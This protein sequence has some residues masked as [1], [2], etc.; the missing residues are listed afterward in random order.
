MPASPSRPAIPRVLLALLVLRARPSTPLH[1]AV[2]GPGRARGGSSFC[3][4][5]LISN[6]RRRRGARL[7][8]AAAADGAADEAANEA[9]D[10]EGGGLVIRDSGLV[11]GDSGVRTSEW[12]LAD[13]HERKT[14]KML[15]LELSTKHIKKVSCAREAGAIERLPRSRHRRHRRHRH[16]HRRRR[17]RRR[18]LPNAHS[19]RT[20]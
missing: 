6:P 15:N 5:S 2:R 14:N 1:A 10:E 17:R 16:R 13:G 12:D 18:S 3:W 19:P 7:S 20:Q 11:I 4:H 8:C 9:G